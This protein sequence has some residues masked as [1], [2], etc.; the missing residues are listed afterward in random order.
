[1]PERKSHPVRPIRP[2]EVGEAKTQS[3]PDEVFQAFNTL[4]AQ[5]Y[6]NGRAVVSQDDVMTLLISLLKG[7]VDRQEVFNRGWLDI[8]DSYRRAGWKVIYDKPGY[9]EDYAATFKFSKKG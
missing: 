2:D 6:R 8:E 4:I 7:E 9:N 3:I 5:N 1:M